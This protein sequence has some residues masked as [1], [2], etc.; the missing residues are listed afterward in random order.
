M[1][2]RRRKRKRRRGKTVVIRKKGKKPIKFKRGALTAEAKRHGYSSARA[3]CVAIGMNRGYKKG[4]SVRTQRRCNLAFKGA[5]AKGR[6]TA[7]RR[8]KRR[9]RR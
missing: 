5:L 4:V 1:A 3:Y 7:K 8:R 9:R 2:K 6:K